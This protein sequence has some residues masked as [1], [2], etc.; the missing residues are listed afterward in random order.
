MDNLEKV[1]LGGGCFWC[2][3]AV[4]NRIIGVSSVRSGYSGGAEVNPSWE[5]VCSGS[6]KH[7][8]VCEIVF[9]SSLICLDDLLLV[10]WEIHDPTTFNRQGHDVGSHY[11]SVIFCEK[12]TDLAI[13]EKSKSLAQLN[14]SNPI[15]SEIAIRNNFYSAGEFHD[16]YFELN[17]SQPYCQ[18]VVSPKVDKLNKRFKDLLKNK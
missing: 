2:L 1:T 10:F 8:E 16:S 6:T 3:E 7:V 11:R 9:D 14:F 4:Y 5:Q 15:V 13:A 17:R 18:F 12:R